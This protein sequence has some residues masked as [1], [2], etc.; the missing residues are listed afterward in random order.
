MPP[1]FEEERD[2]NLQIHW[3]PGHKDFAPNEL[4]DEL[5]KAAATGRS[6]PSRRLPEVLKKPLPAS[7]SALRQGSKTTLQRCWVR[8]WKLSPRYNHLRTIDKSAPSKKWLTLVQPLSRKQ[9][10]IIMQ[11]CTG[12]IGLNKHLHR[13]QKSDTP[14]CPHCQNIIED[15]PHF[16]FTCP[17][18]RRERHVL[19]CELRRRA[20]DI[21][22]LLSSNTATLPLLRYIHATGRLKKT[23]GEVL[24]AQ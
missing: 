14:Y 12:R 1:T 20:Q 7:T 22:F 8:R 16:L 17:T 11:L 23:F 3:V 19:Q 4:A 9:S 10:S 15:I 5:A 18:Y 6:S 13:I 24:S 2:L 21:S